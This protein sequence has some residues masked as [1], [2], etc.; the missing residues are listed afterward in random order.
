[1]I[2][3]R[4]TEP[5]ET[6]ID[7]RRHRRMNCKIKAEVTYG[8]K[9][10]SGMI[11]NLSRSGIFKVVFP[12]KSVIDFFPGKVV[13]VNFH[14]PS[15]QMLNLECEIKWIRIKKGSPLFLKYHMGVQVINPPQGYTGFIQ[16]LM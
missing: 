12:E 14:I 3:T 1:M 4:S 6:A 15:G 5:V 11:E 10:F 2:H 8:T 9:N 16:G 13:G 7:R